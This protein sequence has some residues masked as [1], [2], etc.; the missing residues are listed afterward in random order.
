MSYSNR[1]FFFF[2]P[3]HIWYIYFW[4]VALLALSYIHVGCASLSHQKVTYSFWSQP[5]NH[6]LFYQYLWK[7][8][9]MVLG[10]YEKFWMIMDIV[11]KSSKDAR[12]DIKTPPGGSSLFFMFSLKLVTFWA[13]KKLLY[14]VCF[15]MLFFKHT[16][17]I[18][19]KSFFFSYF[20]QVQT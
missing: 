2:A 4:L 13:F 15:F 16:F 11:A 3:I 9:T 14:K 12:N 17:Y 5:I 20:I 19:I 7:F 10:T 18:F 6:I 1:W 8:N